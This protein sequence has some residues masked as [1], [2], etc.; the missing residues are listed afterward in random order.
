MDHAT[1]DFNSSFI[2]SHK[3][4]L[5]RIAHI[6]LKE[7]NNQ[8]KIKCITIDL[9]RPK[10]LRSTKEKYFNNEKRKVMNL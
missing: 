10:P 5:Q 4:F 8:P 1:F 2:D 3:I 9:E 7:L 6:S